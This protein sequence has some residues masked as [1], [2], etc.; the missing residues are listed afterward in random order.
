VP[1]SP[2]ELP[3]NI[4]RANLAEL[5][6]LGA[7]ALKRGD[8]MLALLAFNQIEQRLG[9]KTPAAVHGLQATCLHSLGRFAEADAKV[10]EGLGAAAATIA[11]PPVFTEHELLTRWNGNSTP[12]VSIICT[13]YNHERYIEQALRGFLSQDTVFPFEILVHEDASTD[14]T[15]DI[16]R[17]WQSRYPTIIRATLQV[18]NQFR[19]GVRPFELMLREARGAYVAVCEGDDYWIAPDKLQQ[20]VSFLEQYREFSCCAHN[21]YHFVESALSI[22]PWIATREM[23]VFTPRQLMGIARL[24]WL[25]TLV[26]RRQFDT[27]PP[28]RALAPIGDQFLTS[29]LGTFGPGMYF[30]SLM[31]AVRRENAHS[32]WSPLDAT[33]KER[34]RVRTWMAVIR[35]HAA[36]GRSQAVT[37]VLAKVSAS[38]LDPAEKAALIEEC[39][40]VHPEIQAA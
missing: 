23:R 5:P 27:M 40:M 37:D 12:V 9:A 31:G 36:A 25:P 28:E 4:E 38:S 24:F 22:R 6:E 3:K 35:M 15:A 18:E 14:R 7:A 39:L 32:T 34:I 21:Y 1:T 8:P 10:S 2:A 29:Y 30:E 20:Q 16:I 26:F 33:A 19:K 11:T 17:E 13:T